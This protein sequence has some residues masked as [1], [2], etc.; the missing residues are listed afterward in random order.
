MLSPVRVVPNKAN[1]PK[2]GTEA[3]SRL[4]I[5]DCGLRSQPGMTALRIGHRP[6]TG[7]PSRP[8]RP[9]ASCTNKP[10]W[11]ER[12]V[13]NKANSPGGELVGQAPP[14]RSA[15]L[16]QTNPICARGADRTR[17][18]QSQFG[19]SRA[20]ACPELAEGTPNLRRVDYAKESQFRPRR[21]DGQRLCEK[22]VMV[23]ST[24]NRPR[25]N[26]AN[27]RGVAQR[28]KQT[29]FGN[30]GFRP[31]VA[32]GGDNIAGWTQTCNGT[33]FAGRQAGGQL[34]KQTQL[35]GANRAKQSQFAEPPGGWGV[36]CT[37][38]ANSEQVG[39]EPVLSLPKER[40]TYEETIVRNKPNSR[41]WGPQRRIPCWGV[42]SAP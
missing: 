26:K 27:S 19:T 16:R 2:R 10:N 34:Y 5:T 24:F 4:R 40:P 15:Q 9:G 11:P 42:P 23:N 12:T 36:N 33:P 6:A 7:R 21:Q 25:Q 22:G 29:Q 39:R 14:Y 31:P 41:S 37:N 35:A 13:R 38:K 20:R 1:C 28:A 30:C 3:V 17:Y 32:A 18:K 8:A